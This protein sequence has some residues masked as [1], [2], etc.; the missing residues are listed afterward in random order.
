MPEVT[1]EE[2]L[3]NR[4]QTSD[5]A[6]EFLG[7]YEQTRDYLEDEFYE[8]VQ[9]ECS[10]FTNHGEEHVSSVMNQASR[11]L[12]NDL[13]NIE[14]GELNELDI[15]ILLT[16]ILW[17][18]VGMVKNRTEHEHISTEVS[19]RFRDIAFPSTAVK[20]VVDDVV[21]GH[22]K[23]NGLDIPAHKNTFNFGDRVYDVY[24]KSLAAVIRFADEISE[25]QERVSG[26]R[27]IKSQVPEESKIFWAY[28]STI[29]GCVP[30][31]NGKQIKLNI[32]LEKD[33]ALADYDCP[34]DFEGR[35]EDGRI[36]LLQYIVCRIEKLINE[37]SYCERHFNRYVEIRNLELSLTIRDDGTH[38]R[39][40]ELETTLGATGFTSPG[41]YPDVEIYSDFFNQYSD[42]TPEEV[43]EAEVGA[44]L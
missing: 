8:W 36:T 18:D 28:A 37:L 38:E 9:A 12:Y 34:S 10:W 43:R 4:A 42:W 15:F 5:N 23:K 7:Q 3:R 20:R 21:K 25:T 22:R 27:W 19:E 13:R 24:P 2:I 40:K 39:L 41:A 1:L 11:L 35:G 26:D 32:E 44:E 6:A 30:D 29:Q 17:H 31:I 33:E 16:S 14:E